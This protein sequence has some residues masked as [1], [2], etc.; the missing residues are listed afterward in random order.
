MIKLLAPLSLRFLPSLILGFCLLSGATPLQ[1]SGM[2]SLEKAVQKAMAVLRDPTLDIPEKQLE[3]RDKLRKIIYAEFDFTA[4]SQGAVGHKWRKFSEKQKSR[5]IPLFKRLLENTYMNT[6]ERYKG[7]KVSFTKEVKQ[8]KTVIRADSVVTSKGAD[9]KVSYR[10]RKNG[11]DW[12]VFD[13]IIEG[14][15]VISNYRSQFQ[16]MLRRENSAEIEKMLARLEHA[17][18]KSAQ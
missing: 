17:A 1:A 15:S 9:F 10:L 5:F 16:Q 13:V 3:R 12:K 4:I 18:N 14:V 11:R 8:S 6:I 2:A 7:E